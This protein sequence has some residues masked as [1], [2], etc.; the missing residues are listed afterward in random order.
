M[1]RRS[2]LPEPVLLRRVCSYVAVWQPIVEGSQL[3]SG[4]SSFRFLNGAYVIPEPWT[5]VSVDILYVRLR[6]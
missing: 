4:A 5:D 2:L 3:S 6:S 1:I